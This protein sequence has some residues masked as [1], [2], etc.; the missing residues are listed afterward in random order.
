MEVT[1]KTRQLM[2][3]TLMTLV[4]FYFCYHLV[5]G[6]KGILALSQLSHQKEQAEQYHKE[7]AEERRELENKVMRLYPQS[8]DLDML[9][10]RAREVLGYAHEG[11]RV[12]Y[13]EREPLETAKN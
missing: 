3:Y 11:E 9:E 10:E 12:Y 1:K 4:V 7:V 13:I 8:L 6:D 5:S 2:L